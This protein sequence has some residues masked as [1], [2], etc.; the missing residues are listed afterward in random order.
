[1]AGRSRLT[2]SKNTGQLRGLV[3]KK[4]VNNLTNKSKKF[5]DVSPSGILRDL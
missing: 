2:Q 3:K 4:R 5:K 1:M